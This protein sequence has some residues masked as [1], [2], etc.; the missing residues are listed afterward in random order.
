METLL[1]LAFSPI[2]L[3]VPIGVTAALAWPLTVAVREKNK[4]PLHAAAAGTSPLWLLAP[5]GALMLTSPLG[6]LL[7]VVGDPV[8]YVLAT[9]PWPLW[10]VLQASLVVWQV[11]LSVKIFRRREEWPPVLIPFVVFNALFS[12][13]IVAVDLLGA[14][15]GA[16]VRS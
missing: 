12:A 3:V 2:L 4:V 8:L 1:N 7:P 14:A 13:V 16:G 6:W 10:V 5:F 9:L 11:S 15:F